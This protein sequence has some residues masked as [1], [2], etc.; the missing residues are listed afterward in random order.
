MPGSGVFHVVGKAGSGKSTMMKFL[1]NHDKVRKYLEHW[2]ASDNKQL[3]LSKFFFW[4]LGS[5]DQK[6]VS[7]LL[8]G[9][10]FDI[11]KHCPD[12]TPL[13][14]EKHWKRREFART[15]ALRMLDSTDLDIDA[16]FNCLLGNHRISQGFKVCL[17]IDGLDKFDEKDKSHWNLAKKLRDWTVSSPPWT[18]MA[19]RTSSSVFPA[20]ITTLSWEYFQHRNRLSSISLLQATYQ[21][22]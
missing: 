11:V 4:K 8:R 13:L 19:V 18:L 14:F 2:A 10:L 15:S 20:E 3:I 21:S 7:G 6:T 12:I 16:A 1:A 17:F 5:D 22:W 9:L